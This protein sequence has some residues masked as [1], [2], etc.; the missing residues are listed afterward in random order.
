MARK[1]LKKISTEVLKKD[2]SKYQQLAIALGAT[3][4]RIIKTGTIVIDERVRA[5]C[6]HP[7]CVQYGTNAN[8]PP[9]AMELDQVKK[10]VNGFKYAIFLKLNVPANEETGT[11]ANKNWSYRRGMAKIFEIVAKVESAAYYD[12][13]YLALGFASGSCKGVFCPNEECTALVAGQRCRYPLK[14][15]S[16]VEG[17]GI[18]AFIMAARLGWDIY[19]LGDSS[20]PDNIPHGTKLG[21]VLIY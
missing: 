5:K 12:G 14:S 20:S 8:C 11:T 10:V 9:F 17:V 7:K 16:S 15:R 19:P 3:D 18:D 21:L 1:I 13:Y 2:L 4:A 6:I